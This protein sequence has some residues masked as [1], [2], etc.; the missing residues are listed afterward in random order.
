LNTSLSSEGSASSGLAG[1][2][3]SI[4]SIDVSSG[5]NEDLNEE[6]SKID[7]IINAKSIDFSYDD[8]KGLNIAFQIQMG[9]NYLISPFLF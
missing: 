6:V 3:D 4:N 9:K 8:P 1:L 7:T 5:N 2:D